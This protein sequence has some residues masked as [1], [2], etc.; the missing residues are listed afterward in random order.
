MARAP[1]PLL[2]GRDLAA[3]PTWPIAADRPL[4]LDLGTGLGHFLAELAARHPD[5]DFVGIEMEAPVAQRAARRIVSAGVANARVVRFDGRNFLAECVPPGS[6][7]H[8]W[9]NFPDPWPKDR[10]A[11][12]RHTHPLMIELMLSRLMVG[13][14]LH[15]ATD[16]L[17]Y[18]ADLFAA[19]SSHPAV[20]PDCEP[21]W[22]RAD[23]GIQ[24][25]YERKW[26]GAGRTVAYHDWTVLHPIDGPALTPTI[27]APALVFTH[28]RPAAGLHQRGNYLARVFPAQ[29]GDEVRLLLI[30][31]RYGLETFARIE[32]DG[33][34]I[35]HGPWTNWKRDLFVDLGATPV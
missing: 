35:L 26:R 27:P 9:V 19:L 2:T 16:A 30:D 8:L 3:A 20:R 10:H 21:A 15:L 31:T 29:P 22:R 1:L 13:G 18:A 17:D 25:K 7:S 34:V 6:L 4:H 12:R 28:E 32:A 11:E 5:A 14:A 33:T 23:L 24:T